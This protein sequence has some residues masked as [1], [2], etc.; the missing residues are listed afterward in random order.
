MRRNYVVGNWKMNGVLAALGVAQAIAQ[1][2]GEHPAVD[3]ALCPP[4]TLIEAMASACPN[5]SVGAQDCH[6]E[7]SGA[8]TG[9]IAA[10]MLADVGAKLVIVGHSERRVGCGE[11]NGTVKAK[12]VAALASGLRIILC[13]GEPLDVRESGK[14]IDY[15][16]QQVVQSVP[17]AALG[18]PSRVAIAYEPI[19]A[20]GTGRVAG[21]SDIAEMH[22]AIRAALGDAG[23]KI[24]IL[25]GG[26]VTA[27]NA[28]AIMALADV[29]GA[30]VG[31]ASLT[32]EKFAPI[33]AAAG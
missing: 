26:S 27:D 5:L 24:A 10:V 19:W 28:A 31:G 20:I 21:L 29:D 32:A 33:I 25:Y 15:V 17:D 8:Y 12:A 9:N 14:A 3:V 2:A 30:L 4:F 6:T 22:S 23:K 13:V 16:L 18:D 11:T 1:I 7:Q